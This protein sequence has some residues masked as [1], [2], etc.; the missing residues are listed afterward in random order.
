MPPRLL[1][2]PPPPPTLPRRSGELF[3]KP[4]AAA[5][6]A[7]APMAPANR[8]P[9]AGFR[10][11]VGGAFKRPGLACGSAAAGA[12]AAAASEPVPPR[13]LHDPHADGAFVLNRQQWAGGKGQ[14]ARG[15]LVCPVVVDSYIGRHLRPHQVW[16]TGCTAR[17]PALRVARSDTSPDRRPWSCPTLR[18][19]LCLGPGCAVQVEGVQFLYEA[20]MGLRSP[21]M[22]GC[23]LADEMVRQP[24]REMHGVSRWQAARGSPHA[25]SECSS[26]LLHLRVC[27]LVFRRAWARRCRCWRWFGLFSSRAPRWVGAVQGRHRQLAVPPALLALP[28]CMLHCL[29]SLLLPAGPPRGT[30]GGGGHPQQPD[31]ELERGGAQVAGG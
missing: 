23:I 5:L 25:C 7:A 3:L 8:P 22:H 18:A 29:P 10:P 19:L 24:G 1:R 27:G 17:L 20:T 30:Q 13:W 12:A 14:L 21:G 16:A 26:A 28:A 2:T 15:R 31:P 4:T 6:L 9:G 11:P